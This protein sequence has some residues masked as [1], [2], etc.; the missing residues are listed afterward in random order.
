MTGFVMYTMPLLFFRKTY[1]PLYSHRMLFVSF[2]AVYLHAQS[3][4][5]IHIRKKECR[6]ENL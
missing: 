1:N 2:P 4:F 3:H 6:Q 5:D